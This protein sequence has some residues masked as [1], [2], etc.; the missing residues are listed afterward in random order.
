MLIKKTK[1]IF[2]LFGF[3]FVLVIPCL[4]LAAGATGGGSFD[5]PI[6]ATSFASL[7]GSIIAWLRNIALLVA[8][9]MILYAG[10]LFMSAGGNETKISNA[11]KTLIY[12]LVGL[13]IVIIGEGFIILL[14]NILNTS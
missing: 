7:L 3:I 8:V 10:L 5:N 12:A 6:E 14:Q 9:F 2:I 13:T 1:P 11:K 4:V